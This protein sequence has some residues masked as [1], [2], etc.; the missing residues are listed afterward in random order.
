MSSKALRCSGVGMG[1]LVMRAPPSKT[2]VLP[3]RVAS[4]SRWVARLWITWLSSWCHRP[5]GSFGEGCRGAP[6]GRDE[7]HDKRVEAPRGS[8]ALVQLPVCRRQG[9]TRR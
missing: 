8:W 7:P 5:S 9:V 2:M 6:G 3:V 4:S 1:S